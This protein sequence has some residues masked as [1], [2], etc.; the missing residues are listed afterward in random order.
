MNIEK[1]LDDSDDDKKES[2]PEEK[3]A[4]AKFA[5]E[6]EVDPEQIERLKKEKIKKEPQT[7]SNL[8]ER[9]GKIRRNNK[10]LLISKN[11]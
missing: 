9:K 3:K 6:D 8:R 5:G 10:L 2:K 11:L 1:G 4:A 7:I